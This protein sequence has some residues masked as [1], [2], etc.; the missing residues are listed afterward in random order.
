MNKLKINASCHKITIQVS[1]SFL[2]LTIQKMSQQSD[3]KKSNHD[4]LHH[5]LINGVIRLEFLSR[6]TGEKETRTVHNTI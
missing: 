4:Q 5:K 3:V 2:D 1:F 6:S